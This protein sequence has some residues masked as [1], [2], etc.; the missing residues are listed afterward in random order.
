MIYRLTISIL[1]AIFFSLSA[2]SLLAG[3]EYSD[4]L[5]T[6]FEDGGEIT[7]KLS[8]GEHEIAVS[9]D[10]NIRVHW[11]VKELDELEDIDAKTGIFGSSAIVEVDG[12]RRGFET[13]VEVPEHSDLVIKISAGDVH[14]GNIK[15]NREINLRAG[16][17]NI[18]VGDSS[19]YSHV[20]GSLWAGDISAGPFDEQASG[21]FRSI[22]W[23]GEGDHK[24]HFK[25]YAGDVQ[26]FQAAD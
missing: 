16:D 25:L 21:L 14:V 23:R 12:P 20:K 13:V 10:D 18:E 24:L 7:I 2:A 11:K 4:S 1:A 9:P 5:V 3:K 26:I 19:D 15:G 8:A 6:E 17:L 22:E